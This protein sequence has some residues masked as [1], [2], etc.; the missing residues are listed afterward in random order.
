MLGERIVLE[1]AKGSRIRIQ[2][3]LPDDWNGRFVGIGSGGYAGTLNERPLAEYASKG[4]AA[5]TTDLGTAPDPRI[6]GFGNPEVIR[7]FGHRATHLMTLE[8]KSRIRQK[9]GRDPKTSYFIGASTGGQQAF[10]LAQRHPDDYDGI[11]AGVPAHSRTALHAY[12]LWNYQHLY[13]PDG[14]ALFTKEQEAS[15]HAAAL[16]HFSQRETFP[17]AAGRFISDPRWREGDKEAVLER[18]VRRDSSLTREHLEA[19]RAVQDGPVHART[20]KRI[21]NGIPP[22]GKFKPA[23]GNLFLFDWAFGPGTDAFGL[24]FGEDYDRYAAL[25]APDLDADNPDL[26]AFKA[27]GGKLIAYSGTA[28][29]CV[30]Y[31]ATLAYFRQVARLQ[32]TEEAMRDFCLYYLLPGREH[33]GGPGVQELYRAFDALRLWR[34][35]GKRPALLGVSC[36]GGYKIPVDP[37]ALF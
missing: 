35:K 6:A 25:F 22:C 14:T 12:F 19:L 5:A 3:V 15:Y 9:Y 11:L 33:M 36:T 18:A 24:D 10:S 31:A 28:D 13:R 34:E 37:F 1:P 30:P 29:S 8:A 21:F 4:Y 27:H 17:R 16:E 23:S 2:L 20:G 32:G 7:D 26:S